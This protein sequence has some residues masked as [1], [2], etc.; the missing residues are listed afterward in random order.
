MLY[1]FLAQSDQFFLF[2]H[3]MEERCIL[4]KK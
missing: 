4:P 2:V 1:I 3:F